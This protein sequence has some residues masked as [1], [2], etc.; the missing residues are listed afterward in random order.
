MFLSLASAALLGAAQVRATFIPTVSG[1]PQLIGNVSDPTIDRD[2]C[3]S[4]RF[5]SRELWTCR[6]SQ[7][8]ANG[9]PTLPI[10]SSSA[11][12]TEFSSDGT[13][14]IQSWTDAAGNTETGLL[15]SGDNYEEPFF[16]IL[17]DECDT[18]TAG[19]CSDNT[20]YVIWP[21]SP[22]LVT[23]E[24]A[25]TG[26]IEAFTWITEAHITDE[27]VTLV[28]DPA[29]TL[30]QITYDPSV[31]GDSTGLP[32]VTTVQENFWT[33]DQMPYGTYGGVVVDDVAYLY[34]QNAA[35]T[36]ALAQV[37]VGSVTDKSAYQYYVNGEWTSTIPGVND[38]DI[39]IA[40]AGAGGQ[41]TFYY[42]S[43]WGLYVWIGQ[44][45]ISIA[46]DF[47]ITT[48]ASPEGPWTEPTNFYSAEYV[49][50]SYTL[51]AHPG[52]LANASE[53]A[54]YLT[55]TVNLAGE[56]Y[57]PLIYVQWES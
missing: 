15:C 56:Y 12:W 37:A 17:A 39:A 57:T 25:T 32:N 33:T 24:D 14:L 22:P 50:E 46:P 52:L 7:P 3:C 54:I 36:V 38:T 44:A 31:N 11:S 35:G 40:N 28:A 43:V 55:Y 53:N 20:R 13:P 4:A 5:G 29:A 8:Y 9:V 21:N 16:P 51:Q 48:A 41:G 42:S 19:A 18:N 6:D 30:Y 26:I 49:T 45:G 10:Y 34:G 27:F 2:S 23:S 1:T 47:Y